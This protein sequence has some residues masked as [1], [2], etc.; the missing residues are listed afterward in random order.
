MHKWIYGQYL[1]ECYE[2][3]HARVVAFT[4]DYVIPLSHS[5]LMISPQLANFRR[6]SPSTPHLNAFSFKHLTTMAPFILH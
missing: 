3:L 5:F 1:L 6:C 4:T 2:N